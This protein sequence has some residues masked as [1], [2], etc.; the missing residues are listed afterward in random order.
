MSIETARL[1][2]FSVGFGLIGYTVGWMRNMWQIYKYF[3]DLYE[4]MKRRCADE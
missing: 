1:I 2:A 3:P 4:E